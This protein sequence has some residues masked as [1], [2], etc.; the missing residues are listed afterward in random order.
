VA[1]SARRTGAARARKPNPVKAVA[2]PVLITVGLLLLIP[3]IWSVLL[4]A[5]VE[6]WNSRAPGAQRMAVVMLIASWPMSICLL[7]GAALFFHQLRSEQKKR[8]QTA[9]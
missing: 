3:G 4:L 5:G 1:G 7:G 9:R 6:V 8:E 2:I